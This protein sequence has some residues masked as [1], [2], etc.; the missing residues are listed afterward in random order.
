MLEKLIYRWLFGFTV[1]SFF[2]IG[3]GPNSQ[4]KQQYGVLSS[5]ASIA[6]R[7]GLTDISK[8]QDFWSAILS[9][10]PTKINQVL[11]PEVSSINKQGQQQKKTLAEF[12]NRSGGTNAEAQ[13]IDD[14]TRA[15]IRTMISNLTSGAASNLASTGSGLL[16]T[17]VGAA[18]EA[19]SAGKTMQEQTLAKWNDIFSSIA[20]TA[21]GFAGMPSVPGTGV[22]GALN[23]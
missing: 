15:A 14:N 3:E 8:A 12:G 21:A 13:T 4:E 23:G 20:K 5:D 10:D 22:I 1:L 16:S 9:G 7:Y 18:A 6:S 17:G 19:F 11:G 2:G